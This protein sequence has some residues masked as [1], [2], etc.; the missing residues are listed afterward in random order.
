MR[1]VCACTAKVAIRILSYNRDRSLK[2]RVF[3]ISSALINL[4]LEIFI[5]CQVHYVGVG[6]AMHV[7]LVAGGA[8]HSKEGALYSYVR[9]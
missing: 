7:G 6:C 5:M 2:C 3:T 1:T 8:H 9:K 4:F